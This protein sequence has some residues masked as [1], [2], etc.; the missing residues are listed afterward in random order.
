MGQYY[1]PVNI[2]KREYIHP[3]KFGDGLKLMEFGSSGSGTMLGLAI[4]LASGNGRGGG[5]LDRQ[6]VDKGENAFGEEGSF[7]P[8]PHERV[9]HA[10]KYKDPGAGVKQTYRTIVPKIVGRWAGDRIV[11]AGDYADKGTFVTQAMLEG[12]TRGDFDL[13][14]HP[15]LPVDQKDVNLNDVAD[16]L[17]TDIS[18][19]VIWALLDD[20]SIRQDCEEATK[21][22]SLCKVMRDCLKLKQSDP[23]KYPLMIHEM[24]SEDGKA[25]LERSIREYQPPKGRKKCKR[26][27]S[28]S[29]RRSSSL[30]HR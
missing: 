29:S 1:F 4:L 11:I 20:L 22:S 24:Q 2:D 14:D 3:H 15:Q 16:K 28:T 12:K 6:T 23:T 26:R 25:F 9:E 13:D 8:L 27:S 19:D 18:F 21:S 10:W 5:D 30:A 17:F 7:D